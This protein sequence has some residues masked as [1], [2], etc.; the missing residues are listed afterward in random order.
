MKKLLALTLLVFTL[1]F[2][3]SAFASTSIVSGHS[4]VLDPGHGGTDTGTTECPALYE[5]AANLQ[6]ALILQ[7]MLQNAG[8]TVYMTRITDITLTNADR[9]NFANST[10]AQIFV[11]V[12][13]NGSTNHSKD[14]NETLYGKRIKDYKLATLVHAPAPAELNV[15]DLGVTNF[16]DGVLL[17]TIM[18]A[19]LTESV[20][21]SNT[22]ECQQMS[23]GTMTRQNQIVKALFDGI[24][25]YFSK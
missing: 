25:N 14:G 8:A 3:Q 20:Y 19:T 5:K 17:K 2:S 12:H 7:Q 16:A 6:I 9:Y 15:P 13:L 11:S 22:T 10:G 4:V 18:P 24:A 21:L 23:D 1:I